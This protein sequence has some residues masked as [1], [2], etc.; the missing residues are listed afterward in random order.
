M[1]HIYS[2]CNVHTWVPAHMMLSIG[3]MRRN[4]IQHHAPSD[5]PDSLISLLLILD[6]SLKPFEIMHLF[7]KDKIIFKRQNQFSQ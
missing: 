1:T 3:E 5:D 2:L 4:G 7:L 6:F